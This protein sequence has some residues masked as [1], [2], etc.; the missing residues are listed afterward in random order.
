MTSCCAFAVVVKG[1]GG[2]GEGFLADVVEI[3]VLSKCTKVQRK[4]TRYVSKIR[5]L[6]S[7]DR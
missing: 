3:C 7:V 2:L 4:D 6:R 1:G 5:L